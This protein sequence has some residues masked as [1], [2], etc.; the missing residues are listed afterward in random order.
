MKYNR[1]ER[2]LELFHM[3][4]YCQTA[5]FRYIREGHV[6]EYEAGDRTIIRDI[7]FLKE[8]GLIKAQYSKKERAYVPSD[9]GC[10]VPKEFQPLKLPEKKNQRIYMEKIIRLCTLMTDVVKAQE[11]DPLRWY[12]EKYPQL[13]ERTRQRDFETL[14]KVGYVIKYWPVID[15]EEHGC[16][17]YTIRGNT[18]YY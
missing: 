13:S 14:R 17:G 3:F 12:R 11:E 4:C 15:E 5:S 6:P 16:W 8:A 18:P 2:L 7:R 9:G 10:F 1:T